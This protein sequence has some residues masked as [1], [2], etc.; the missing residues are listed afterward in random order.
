MEVSLVV[1]FLVVG[2]AAVLV[3]VLPLR[4]LPSPA[5]EK[6]RRWRYGVYF[7]ATGLGYLAL[8]VAL[9]QKF[10]LFLGHPSYALSVVLAFLLLFT[11]L[12][13]LVSEALVARLGGVRFASYALAFVVLA[14]HLLLLPHL[15]RFASLPFLARSLLVALLVAPLAL[16]LGVFLPTALE[17]LKREAPSFVPWAWGLNGVFSVLS[18]ILSVGIAMTFGISALLLSALPLYLLAGLCLPEP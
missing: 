4:A 5:G 2:M 17:R 7:A 15:G 12:G 11:G 6:G 9:L 18:P 14:E 10:G 3:V 1:L 8:E 16:L 13:S